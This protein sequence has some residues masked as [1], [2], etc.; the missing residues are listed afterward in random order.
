MA[1]MSSTLT[2]RFATSAD[3]ANL[4]PVIERAYRGDSA[5]TGWTH[6][7]DLLDDQRTDLVTLAAILD[8]P[9][10]RLLV[11]EAGGSA[12]GCVQISDRDGGVAYLGLL[13][14]DPAQ[15]AGGMGRQLIAAAE[16]YA[17]SCFG[18]TLMEMTVID[19][20]RELVAY[21]ER[22]GYL[23]SGEVRDFP[24]PVRP[25]L[26]MVVLVKTLSGG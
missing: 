21:Y 3:L 7:A 9:S 11:A 14:I 5:R 17:V 15:Q 19:S 18:A 2:I 13:C 23:R 12:V 10:E 4:H 20:R 16:A 24:V 26:H 22:R 8:N 1:G 25:P 6:E